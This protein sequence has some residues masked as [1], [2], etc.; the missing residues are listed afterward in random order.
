MTDARADARAGRRREGRRLVPLTVSLGLLIVTAL[1]AF[2]PVLDETGWWF[3][4]VAVVAAVAGASAL[5][6]F[7]GGARPLGSIVGAAAGVLAVT[8]ICGADTTLAGILPTPGTIGHFVDLTQSAGESIYRQSI[9]AHA[10]AGITFLLIFAA[11]M[12]AVS[13]DLMAISAGA[14]APVGLV[15]LAIIIPPSVLMEEL[16]VFAF[17][18]TALTYLAVLWASRVA[19]G[20]GGGLARMLSIGVVAAS[21]AGIGAAAVPGFNGT[22]PFSVSNATTLSSS[23]SPLLNLGE[24][25]QRTGNS[26]QFRYRTSASEPPR[27]RMMTLETFDGE[28]WSSTQERSGVF[29]VEP[30]ESLVRNEGIAAPSGTPVN[31][32]VSIA[33]LRDRVLPI[34]DGAIAID[35]ADGTWLWDPADET[36]RSASDSTT[37]LHYTVASIRSAPTAESLRAADI[38]DRGIFAAEREVPGD[39][40]EVITSTLETVIEGT[41]NPYARAHA[42]QTFL[43]D[44]DFTYSLSAPVAQGY[45]GDGLDVIAMFLERRAGYCVHFAA[46]MATMARLIDIPSRIVLGFLPGDENNKGQHTVTTEDLHAWPELF[47][48]GVG[49]VAFE[50]TPGRGS[51]P[52][53]APEPTSTAE[54]QAPEDLDPRAFDTPTARETTQ[55]PDADTAAP[56]SNNNATPNLAPFGAIG[57]IVLVL[58]AVPALVRAARRT[59]RLRRAGHDRSAIDAAWAEIVDTAVDLGWQHPVS[60]TPRRLGERILTRIDEG[61]ADESG[62]VAAS[63]EN[64]MRA[65]ERARYGPSVDSTMVGTAADARVVLSALRATATPAERLRA[66]MWP[67]SVFARGIQPT[68]NL[69]G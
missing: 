14:A 7:L 65:V 50:P 20:R 19:Q 56:D 48:E 35:G 47:F 30:G 54:A 66:A 9:P 23:V 3:G 31:T 10:D 62:A 17:A 53:Y 37:G 57:G 63:V 39:V 49:W 5:A 24:D 21:I 26:V 13:I 45:D 41:E 8:A 44:G 68:T 36:V 52:A 29:A 69:A 46:T 22:N 12:A 64:L 60:D 59:R 61:G 33:G 4:C 2:L 38:P 16:P 32:V 55:T 11:L 28:T 18:A 42:I 51:T 67:P 34:P 40:P 58:L 27:F 6:R 25:L 15:A 43:R 1:S